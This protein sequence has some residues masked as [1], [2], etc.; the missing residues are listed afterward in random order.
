MIQRIQSIFLAL[1]AGAAGGLFALPFATTPETIAGSELFADGVFNLKDNPALMI[2]FLTAGALSL[3]A[4]FLFQ[5]RKLQ[6]RLSVV[7][8]VAT[9]VGLGL[10]LFFFLSDPAR[11]QAAFGAGTVLP[12]VMMLFVFLGWRN[13]KKDEKLV[14]SIDRLR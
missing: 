12:L 4:I 6:M 8:I 14:R 11:G 13:I 5:N 1:A 9:V 3:L 10:G 7:A 2:A